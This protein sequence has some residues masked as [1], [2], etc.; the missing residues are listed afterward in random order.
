MLSSGSANT[1]SSQIL[2]VFL[3]CADSDKVAARNLYNKL[4]GIIYGN[5]RL[6][7]TK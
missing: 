5:Y 6:F 1:Q 3:Y 4:Q 2:Q 7:L